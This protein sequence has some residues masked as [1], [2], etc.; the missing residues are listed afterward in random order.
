M[1]VKDLQKLHDDVWSLTTLYM[2]L[3]T[4]MLGVTSRKLTCHD[5]ILLL[6]HAKLCTYVTGLLLTDDADERP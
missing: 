1:P 6:L 3:Q 2:R 5:T 4:T